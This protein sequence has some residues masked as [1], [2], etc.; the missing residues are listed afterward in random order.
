MIYQEVM[1]QNVLSKSEAI[2]Y[3][4]IYRYVQR[5]RKKRQR[6][7]IKRDMINDFLLSK[8]KSNVEREGMK[9]MQKNCI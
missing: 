6:E 5:E 9:V 7:T 8:I 3:I 2:V 4:Y 1:L